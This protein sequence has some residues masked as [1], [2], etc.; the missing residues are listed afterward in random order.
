MNS[1]RTLF[2]QQLPSE[3]S[4]FTTPQQEFKADPKRF[5]TDVIGS[6]LMAFLAIPV[7][8]VGFFMPPSERVYIFPIS[9]AFGGLMAFGAF[10]VYKR[11]RTEKNQRVIVYREGLLFE[12]GEQREAFAWSEIESVW[13]EITTT[14]VN[15]VNAGTTHS[16]KLRL[17][18]GRERKVDNAIKD[19]QH[20][21][22]IIQKEV[23]EHLLP[24]A[25]KAFNAG[26]TVRFGN[27]EVSRNGLGNGKTVLSWNEIKQVRI[28]SG[29]L[30]IN[31]S[32]KWLPWSSTE[33]SKISNVFV[34]CRLIEEILHPTTRKA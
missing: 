2:S 19:I 8:V 12:V 30:M 20:L 25:I 3:A 10:N 22:N 21:G 18:K 14:Y 9:L 6:S 16:Y 26:E 27:L 23:T 31:K 17:R 34:L 24:Q 29:Q 7:G 1:A 5:V 32:G 15:G 33:I 4:H 11:S 13:Q 28:E